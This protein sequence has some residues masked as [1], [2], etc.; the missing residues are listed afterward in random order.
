[1]KRLLLLSLLLGLNPPVNAKEICTPT[2]ELVPD[3]TITL[4]YIGYADGIGI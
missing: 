2:S 3:E 4:K 1:M